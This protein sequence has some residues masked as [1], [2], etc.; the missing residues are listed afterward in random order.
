MQ[1]A[2]FGRTPTSN[3]GLV[4]ATISPEEATGLLRNASNFHVILTFLVHLH[5]ETQAFK[6]AVLQGA[7]RGIC[8]PVVWCPASHLTIIHIHTR[9]LRPAAPVKLPLGVKAMGQ[10]GDVPPQP[11]SPPKEDQ[12]HPLSLLLGEGI[13]GSTEGRMLLLFHLP[14]HKEQKQHPVASHSLREG[15]NP[16]HKYKPRHLSK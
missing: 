9:P 16:H 14:S 10:A 5:L 13:M 4:T 1:Q 11:S 12:R 8:S 15:R 2:E 3:N 6:Q 7:E